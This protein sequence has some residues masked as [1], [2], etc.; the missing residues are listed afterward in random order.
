MGTF[1]QAYSSLLSIR[2]LAPDADV[3]IVNYHSQKRY[4]KQSYYK[5]KL[6]KKRHIYLPFLFRYIRGRYGYRNCQIHFLGIEPKKGFI[7][8]SHEDI[9]RFLN[10][11]QY[12][13]VFVGS[14]T[15]LRLDEWHYRDDHL[16][17][18]WIPFQTASKK[19]L[20]AASVDTTFNIKRLSNKLKSEIQS[21]LKGF[22]FLGVRDPISYSAVKRLSGNSNNRVELVPDPTFSYPLNHRPIDIYL[23]KKN[24]DFNKPTLGL[25]VPIV[26]PGIKQCVT[27]LKSKGFQIAAWRYWNTYTDYD[28]M[29]MTPIEWSGVFKYLDLTITDRFHAAIFSLKNLTPVIAIDYNPKRYLDNYES[30]TFH[31]M[32]QFNSVN[33]CHWNINELNDQMNFAMIAEKVLYFYNK[34]NLSQLL[35]QCKKQYTSYLKKVLF[36]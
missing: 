9:N 26:L 11:K 6:F 13:I 7:S 32:K 14:D 1:M 22:D 8:D 33:L 16:P 27:Y 4:D 24:F 15:V 18:Y 31:L 12:D 34:E 23:K 19:A 28:L 29:G 20:L 5:L 17:A 2:K 35:D 36:Q 3:E 21:S 30:K 10:E 25:D